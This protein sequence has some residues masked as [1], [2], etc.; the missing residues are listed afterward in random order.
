MTTSDERFEKGKEVRSLLAGGGGRSFEGSVPSA[1]ELA[2][3]MYK[4]TTE[5]LYG[6]VWTREGL[7]T[8]YR[9]M[10]TLSAMAAQ[11]TDTQVRSAIRVCLD[12]GVAADEIV[13]ILMMASFNA[14]IPA[15]H[16]GLA[17][18]K[19]VFEERGIQY[20]ATEVYDSSV[21][22]EERYLLGFR[23]HEELMPDV[24]GYHM[25]E[26]TPEER[27]LDALM[28][29]YYWG[30][31]WTRPGLDIKSRAICTLASTVAQGRYDNVIRRTIEGSIRV[32]VTRTE[33]MEMFIHLSLYVGVMPARTAM[34][35]A[36]SIFRSPEFTEANTS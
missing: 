4:I 21:S 26:P 30:S 13:E 5:F 28:T 12:V 19:E 33:L 14:G 17:I 8:R 20:K 6:T 18:A 11:R 9:A 32:G 31:I 23:Q 29:E 1:Y 7:D 24:F 25:S 10:I 2:P 36:T 15:G 35:I 22:L 27:E 34:N 3:D 16:R